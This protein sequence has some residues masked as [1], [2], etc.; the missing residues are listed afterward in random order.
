MSDTKDLLLDGGLNIK[1]FKKYVG[2]FLN[3]T[4]VIYGMTDSG[5]ST[6]IDEIMY[7]CKDYITVPFVICQSSITVSS[8][9]YYKKIPD[10]CIKSD[11]S[12][13][14]LEDFMIVQ[15][16]RAALF[17]TADNLDTLKSVFEKIN[18]SSNNEKKNMI[19]SNAEKYISNINNSN[20]DFAQKKM[21][22]TTIDKI[23][24]DHLKTLYKSC[25]R[26]NKIKLEGMSKLSPDEICC[27]NYVDFIP[28]IMIIF[29]DCAS[30]F[31]K[32]VKDSTIIKEMFY[33]GRHYYITLIISAQ[34]DK[35]IESELRKNAKVSIFTSQQAA[36]SNFTRSA[37]N[38]PKSVK[39]YAESCIT[40]IFA[41]IA[42]GKNHK[43]LVYFRNNDSDPFMYT[44]ADLYPPFKVGCKG[45]WELD[46]KINDI[47]NTN[48]SKNAF[49][50]Q[51]YNLL[52]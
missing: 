35:E 45:I 52:T 14:W 28:N 9:P 13:E 51:H 33:N 22:I 30:K 24:N 40:K 32:W 2:N 44:I 46:Q 12:K 17:D 39:K 4:T 10:H 16:G 36:S 42:I 26:N 20:L 11:V 31:K 19:I 6:I 3:R 41:P 29:D 43:K 47:N 37:N 1:W 7:I 27:I 23:K 34:D 50:N 48:S 25:I 5:K 38:Y 49:F 8:S 21:Q 18:N 15:K